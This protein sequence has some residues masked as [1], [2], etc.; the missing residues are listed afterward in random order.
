M[1]H[2]SF[3]RRLQTARLDFALTIAQMGEKCAE[4]EARAEDAEQTLAQAWKGLAG[5]GVGGIYD[6]FTS[7]PDAIRQMALHSKQAQQ[8]IAE[9]DATL[10]WCIEYQAIVKFF[11]LQGLTMQPRVSVHSSGGLIAERDDLVEA[12]EFLREKQRGRNES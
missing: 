8:R 1:D 7:L 6:A 5:A 2:K 4:A 10:G 9:L 3:E 12:V 11:Y